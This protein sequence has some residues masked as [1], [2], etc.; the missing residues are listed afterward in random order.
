MQNNR[1]LTFLLCCVAALHVFVFS[2]A[3]PFFSVADEQMH[4]DLVVRYA[5]ADIPRKLTPPATEALPFLAIYG[6]PEYLW[7]PSALPGGII[8]PPPWKQPVD[9]VRE[10]L[11]IKKDA[12]QSQFRNHE[13]ASPPLYYTL[14]GAWWRL[15]KI[16]GLDGAQQL[17]WLR[18]L[19][20]PLVVAL[21][22]LGAFAARKLFP[23]NYLVQV[24][25]PALVAFLPQTVFYSINNDVVAPL[26]FGAG[27]VLLLQFWAAE[28]PSP[29]L[30]AA[31]GLA[32]AA[33]FLA[34]ISCLPFRHWWFYCF[35][36]G[37]RWPRG[38]PG[39][40]RTSATGP[41]P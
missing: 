21:T 6:T 40:K 19:N 22:W 3:F 27:F 17:Y 33:T 30:G 14:A 18:F 23:E 31:T 20:V 26:A 25:V 24:A 38:W 41:A 11:L 29:R 35:A 13:A 32:L 1:A 36:R 10:K 7:T 9:A 39:A 5:Q 12:Y 15:G 34:K 37:C 2:A 16:L 8:P 4:F 28:K